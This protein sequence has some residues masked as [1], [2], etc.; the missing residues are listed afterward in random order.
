MLSPTAP[1][2]DAV[3]D[4]AT[5]PV[6]SSSRGH[7]DGRGIGEDEASLR[8][9]VVSSRGRFGPVASSHVREASGIAASALHKNVFWTHNDSGD[10]ARAF[11]LRHDGAVAL[12]V[13]FGPIAPTDIEDIAIEDVNPQSS[14]LYFADIG[15]NAQV[16]ANVAIYRVAEPSHLEGEQ[17]DLRAE[18]MTVRYE[19]GARNAETL[20]FDPRTKNLYIATKKKGGPARVYRVGPFVPSGRVVA[21]LVTSVNVSLATGGDISRDGRFIALRTTTDAYVWP[22]R[23]GET[24]EEAL[25]RP[26]CPMAVAPE[27]Q[28]E[29]FAFF[30]D[31]SGFVTLS[32]GESQPMHFARFG[33]D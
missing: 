12:T 1:R 10:R 2:R 22:R 3:R 27:P 16:R 20:L 6:Q 5:V 8:C 23:S 24:L 19:D 17:R 11:A 18:R 14:N 9:P 31:G 25:A 7:H 28:G 13:R 4:A 33:L 26:P 30:A 21:T 15:D 29:A 32:E